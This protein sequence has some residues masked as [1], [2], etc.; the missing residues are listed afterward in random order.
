MAQNE[1]QHESPLMNMLAY[2]NE[3]AEREETKTW[4]SNTAT[5]QEPRVLWLGC[6]DSRIS[7]SLLC[8]TKPGEVFVH[9]NIANCFVSAAHSA[10]LMVCPY[11]AI[12]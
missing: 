1:Q 2:N 4:I 10:L 6:A 9:R 12:P 8:G 3:W 11:A 7:E 5:K